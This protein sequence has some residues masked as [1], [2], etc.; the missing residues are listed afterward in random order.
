[1]DFIL[2]NK[3]H[4]D[5]SVQLFREIIN[6]T[7]RNT[8][9]SAVFPIHTDYT[10]SNCTNYLNDAVTVREHEPSLAL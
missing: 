3:I 4:E 6:P 7:D 2:V 10:C 9:K 5:F 8:V 1:M